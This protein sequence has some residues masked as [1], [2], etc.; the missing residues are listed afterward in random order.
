LPAASDKNADTPPG[1]RR[2]I[3]QPGISKIVAFAGGWV[4]K[5]GILLAAAN[6]M[7]RLEAPYHDIFDFRLA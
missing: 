7:R 2:D 4:R 6:P 3:Y 1:D 5:S